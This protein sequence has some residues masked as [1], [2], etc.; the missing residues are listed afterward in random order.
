MVMGLL[1]LNAWIS[2]VR[3]TRAEVLSL[4]HRDY[5]ALAR[6]VGASNF[7]IIFRHLLPGVANTVIVLATLSVGGYILTEATLSFLGAGIPPPNPAW[8]AM[9]AEGNT[10]LPSHCKEY[11]AFMFREEFD[12]SDLTVR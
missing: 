11:Y 5:V 12:P 4:K 8:E 7:R 2:F 1:I 10:Y 3:N 6:V 9:V